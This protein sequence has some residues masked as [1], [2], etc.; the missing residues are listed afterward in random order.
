METKSKHKILVV[1]GLYLAS[2]CAFWVGQASMLIARFNVDM[3]LMDVREA[4]PGTPFPSDL[5]LLAAIFQSIWVAR[6]VGLLVTIPVTYYFAKQLRFV[7]PVKATT[8]IVAIVLLFRLINGA[9][10]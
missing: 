4:N 6:L 3:K 1:M 10:L 7:K 9:M 5:A 8:I 2:A